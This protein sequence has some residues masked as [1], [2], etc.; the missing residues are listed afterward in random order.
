MGQ[1]QSLFRLFS[2]F[3]NKQYNFKINVKNVQMPIK[4]TKS[5]LEPTTLCACDH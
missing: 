2:V 5:W 4:Y 3:S 1:P